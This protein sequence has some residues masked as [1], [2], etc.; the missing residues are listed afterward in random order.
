MF[1]RTAFCY[2]SFKFSSA[3]FTASITKALK[4]QEV[5][6]IAIS[7]SSITSLG[8][9]M[10][11][12]VLGGTDGILNFLIIYHLCNTILYKKIFNVC[13]TNALQKALQCDI[14]QK[15]NE[16][17]SRAWYVQNVHRK[18]YKLRSN[19]FPLKVKTEE[20]AVFGEFAAAF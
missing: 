10:H 20:T 19:R 16:R 5:P 3:T 17:R 6:L 18:T 14:M 2:S 4:V 11:L 13:I 1:N 12:F 7:I 9:R 8:K 15:K